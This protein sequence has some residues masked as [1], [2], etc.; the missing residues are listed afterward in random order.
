M[1]FWPAG[2]DPRDEVVGYIR[3]AAI[4]APSGLARFMIGDTGVFRDRDGNAWHGA[5]LVDVSAI[6]NAQ[7][8]KAP[9][10]TVTMSYFQDPDAPDLIEE[11][12]ASG[13]DA[14]TGSLVRFYLQPL[15]SV[16]EFYA[17]TD[18]PV[19]RATL[20]A[21]GLSFDFQGDVQRSIS[22]RLESV[23]RARVSRRGRVYSVADHSAIVGES[24]PSLEY[25]PLPGEDDEKLF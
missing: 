23:M 19:L 15:G 10:T 11:I 14:I 7:G 2:F 9:Q 18:A 24:N 12:R 1:T 21:A 8:G 5:Q 25:I 22:L 17:P 4:D 20:R 6:G 3:L 16:E 13:D